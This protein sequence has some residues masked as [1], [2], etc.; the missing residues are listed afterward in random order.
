VFY[1]QLI[2]EVEEELFANTAI[3]C[4]KERLEEVV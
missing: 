1:E 4:G 3:A 2:V